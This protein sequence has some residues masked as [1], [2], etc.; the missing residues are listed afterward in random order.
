MT[1]KQKGAVAA[2]VRR[3]FVDSPGVE[4]YIRT[5]VAETKLERK[6][7]LNVLSQMRANKEP[8]VTVVAGQ[9]YKYAPNADAT[10]P[11]DDELHLMKFVGT[12]QAGETLFQNTESGELWKATKI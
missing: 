7:V 12:L 6:Q 10:R 1:T 8:L 9:I 11:E 3:Y 5:I 4:V 2:Q